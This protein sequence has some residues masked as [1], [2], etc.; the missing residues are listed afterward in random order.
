MDDTSF[1]ICGVCGEE[2]DCGL[3]FAP[4]GASTILWSCTECLDIAPHV[5]GVVGMKMSR[6]AA[7]A[8]EKAGAAGGEYLEKIGQTDLGKLTPDQWSA[9]LDTLFRA[10][11]SALRILYAGHV[12]GSSGNAP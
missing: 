6:Y 4:D 1:A 7:E 11:S 5:Y 3:G 9:F 10:R 2:H 12:P 8:R